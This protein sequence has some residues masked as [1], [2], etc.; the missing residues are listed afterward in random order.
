MNALKL[1][2]ATLAT[3]LVSMG[4]VCQAFFNDAEILIDRSHNNRTLTIRYIGANATLAELRINGT[5]VASRALDPRSSTGETNFQLD[6]ARLNDG[7]NQVEIRLFDGSGKIVGTQRTE[8]LYDRSGNGPVYLSRP[9]SGETIQGHVTI[10]LGF[11]E[12]LRNVYVSFFINDEFKSLRNLPPYT[13]V[14]DTTSVPNGWHEV[15]AWVV[16]STNQTFKTERMKLFVN[17]PG[18]RTDRNTG[19]D[20]PPV[21][22]TGQ[23]TAN[24]GDPATGAAA[25]VRTGAGTSTATAQ[26]GDPIPPVNQVSGT[27]SAS[28]SVGAAGAMSGTKATDIGLGGYTD[29]R[30]MTPTGERM[31]NV[32]LEA[33]I[34][35]NVEMTA[36]SI[37]YGA[38]V[39]NIGTFAIFVDGGLVPFDVMP[40]VDEKGIPLTPFR[41]LF[42]HAGGEVE[43]EHTAKEVNANAS[44]KVVWFKVGDAYAR[45]DDERVLL[46][47]APFIESGRTMV[48][49]SFITRALD[50]DIEF[51]PVSGH[52]LITSARR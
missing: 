7:K 6:T 14:W 26:S 5:S 40:R 21:Q 23:G 37:T 34:P 39:P 28:G 36:V 31:A 11:K 42:E 10:A 32:E 33:S 9:A 24:A 22:S 44:G 43:W 2:R 47:L 15:Q 13:Y 18:G 1:M 25:G 19:P 12:E 8:I 35:A 17:N 45:V 41:H 20:V 3:V 49:L 27:T 48:P 30:I 51:D 16:D 46:E 52:V 50:V 4:F 29:S 38:R